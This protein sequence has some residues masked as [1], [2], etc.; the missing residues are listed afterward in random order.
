MSGNSQSRLTGQTLAERVGVDARDLARRRA[1]LDLEDA[2]VAALARFREPAYTALDDLTDGF[3][4]RLVAEPGT[5]ALV[6]DADTLRRLRLGL[7][8][9][10]LDLF[11]GS[12]DE[13]YAQGRLQLGQLHERLE[14]RPAHLVEIW[15]FLRR[16]LHRVITAAEPDPLALQAAALALGK[17]LDLDAGLVFDVYAA[18][19]QARAGEIRREADER[20][21]KVEAEIARRTRELEDQLRR[22]PLTGLYNQ[23][24]FHDLLRR[25]LLLAERGGTALSL[26]YFDIDGFKAIND[27][28]GHVEGDRVLTD[29]AA[30]C[31]STLR[32]IDLAC[33]YGGDEFCIIMPNTTAP[34]AVLVCRRLCAALAERRP[35]LTLSTGVAQTGPAYHVHAFTL[36]KA[37]DALMYRAKRQGRGLVREDV[38][39]P[40]EDGLRGAPARRTARRAKE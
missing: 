8:N 38:V 20:V 32:A 28:L 9:Y 13:T 21:A 1:R 31:S 33:R 15:S 5:A 11:G 36:V 25:D 18:N 27:S 39:Q 24:A 4:A 6:G 3:C 40:V 22:D 26:A 34:G 12:Y 7:R 23:R 29:V 16:E 30:A 10:V 35:G 2:D 14:V 19:L 37:A 17:A